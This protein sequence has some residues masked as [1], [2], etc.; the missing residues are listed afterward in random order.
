MISLAFLG[1]AGTVTGSRYL[2][3]VHGRSILIDAGLF[4]G[5]KELRLRNWS[6]LP[7]DA[8]ELDAVILTHAHIDHTGFLPCLARGGFGGPT[9]VTPP[10]RRLLPPLLE[11]AAHLQEEEARFANK[12]GSSRHTPALPLFTL[13]DVRH[14][15]AGVRAQPFDQPLELRPGLTFTFHRQGHILGAAAVEVR[16]K[17]AGRDHVTIY[18]SGD[19]GRYD[20]PI[21]REPQP[22]PGSSY[23]V[24]ESTYG[25]RFHD[26]A[27]PAER[28]AGVVAEATGRGGV[29]LIP[30]FA[31]DR[32]Q[33]VL[34]YLR[35]LAEDEVI[36]PVPVFLDSP[37]AREATEA[38]RASVREHDAEMRELENEGID[39]LAPPGLTLVGSVQESQR[40][41][42]LRG[43]AIV[44]SASGMATGGRIL[45][46]LRHRL[47]EEANTVL[48]VGYQAAGTRGRRIL[49][50][51]K[52]VKIFGELVPVRACV[53]SISSLSAHADADELTIWASSAATPPRKVFVTHGEPAA[54]AALAERFRSRFGWE[55]V[56]PRLEE[57]VEL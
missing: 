50:G 25:D 21:L 47:G 56:L 19:V 5:L 8:R 28:L 18:F 49:D 1:A 13:A 11:D 32:T 34:Y 41:N 2:L 51:E 45:H 27:D 31:I 30:A 43:P 4:Q 46:H 15:L 37:M 24:V 40:L 53:R 26:P 17:A 9:F 14:A 39:P 3:K 35:Q 6:P 55:C 16:V 38:Y 23:L 29:L 22:Y 48:F 52:T 57:T 44:I 36:A 20:V 10:T 12:V 54:S 42:A 33:E 7:V